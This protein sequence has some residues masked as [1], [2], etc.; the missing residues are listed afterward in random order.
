MCQL[1]E[2]CDCEGPKYLEMTAACLT[3]ETKEIILLSVH[4]TFVIHRG[5][6]FSI[7]NSSSCEEI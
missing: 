7:K 6:T 1:L 4:E 2:F 3:H 5:Q